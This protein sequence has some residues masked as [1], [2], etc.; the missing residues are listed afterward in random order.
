MASVFCDSG[1]YDVLAEEH[2]LWR[3]GRERT[4][5]SPAMI[6]VHVASH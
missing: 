5:S 1:L 6:Q 3:E 4:F 2:G